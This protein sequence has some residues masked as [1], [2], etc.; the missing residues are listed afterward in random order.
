MKK[1]T[2]PKIFIPLIIVLIALG[3]FAATTMSGGSG[4]HAIVMTKNTGTNIKKEENYAFYRTQS[5]HCRICY[6]ICI[7]AGW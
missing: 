1:L 7:M 2:D 3:A 5:W 6:R 4:G